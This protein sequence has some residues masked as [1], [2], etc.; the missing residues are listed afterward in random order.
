MNENE[1]FYSVQ[2]IVSE[3]IGNVDLKIDN[4]S[5]IFEIEGWD[6]TANV[7][8]LIN[9]ESTFKVR[10]EVEEIGSIDSIPKLLE[11]IKNKISN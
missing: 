4:D 3:V 10:F 5:K 1:I 7:E 9:L 2:K 11:C 6:S 8:I